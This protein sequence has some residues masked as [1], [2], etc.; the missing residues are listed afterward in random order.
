MFGSSLPPVI[1]RKVYVLFM[2][3]VFVCA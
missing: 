3:L 1:C 2:L